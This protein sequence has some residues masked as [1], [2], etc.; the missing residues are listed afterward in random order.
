MRISTREDAHIFS[1]IAEHF[2]LRAHNQFMTNNQTIGLF[3]FPI[4]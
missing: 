3:L 2:I 1:A 4:P